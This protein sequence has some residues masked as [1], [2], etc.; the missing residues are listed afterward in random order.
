M[1]FV[2]GQVVSIL[3]FGVKYEKLQITEGLYQIIFLIFDQLLVLVGKLFSGYE[4]HY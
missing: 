3:F 2:A 1:D 4:N